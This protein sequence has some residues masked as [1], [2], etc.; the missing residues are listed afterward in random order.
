MKLAVFWLHIA[1]CSLVDVY[2]HFRDACCLCIQG[3]SL[4]MEAANTCKTVMN[5]Y[6]TTW[7]KNS[8]ES[9]LQVQENFPHNLLPS[10][11]NV[12]VKTSLKTETCKEKPPDISL[13]SEH[14][15]TR[16]WIGATLLQK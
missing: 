2:H 8:E 13:P 10:I 14:I 7:H 16:T 5:F 11:K 6:K 15:L 1:S 12:F 4:L 9:Q 3:I